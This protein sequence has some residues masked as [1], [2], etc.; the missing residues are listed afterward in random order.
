MAA[1]SIYW[2]LLGAAPWVAFVPH[3]WDR[4]QNRR[5]GWFLLSWFVPPLVFFTLV[6]I[7]N[8]DHALVAI[9]AVCLAGAWVLSRLPA[10]WFWRAAPAVLAAEVLL[11]FYPASAPFRASNY[12]IAEYTI[13]S[14]DQVYARIGL[15]Q[16]LGPVTVLW[17][18]GYITPQEIGYYFPRVPVLNLED[19]PVQARLGKVYDWAAVA[20]GEVAISPGEVVWLDPVDSSRARVFDGLVEAAGGEAGSEGAVHW[21]K[22]LPGVGFSV[23][24]QRLRAV[25]PK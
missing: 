3:A 15:L 1:A 23:A 14:A 20:D 16:K 9:P 17:S 4:L 25:L 21:A 11:F 12:R 8:P 5:G 18:G 24:G 19:H 2:N 22:L 10:G 6:H 13:R 7:H